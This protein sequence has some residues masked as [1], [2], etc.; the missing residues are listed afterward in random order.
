MVASSGIPPASSIP[1]L[2]RE[3]GEPV[4][5]VLD[6]VAPLV[7]FGDEAGRSATGT[8]APLAVTDLV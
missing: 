1:A 7:R 4:D 5:A 3:T 2:S 8:A 6:R